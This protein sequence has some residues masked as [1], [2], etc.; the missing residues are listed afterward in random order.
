M[1]ELLYSMGNSILYRPFLDFAKPRDGLSQMALALCRSM[2]MRGVKTYIE[3]DRELQR[4]GRLHEDRYIASNLSSNDLMVS[5]I[6]A[7]L[8]FADCPDLP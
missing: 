5:T 6:L 3:V 2:A 8:E 4:G 1:L 7:P